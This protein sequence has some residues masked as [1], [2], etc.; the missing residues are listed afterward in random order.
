[1][2][3]L[4]H[5]VKQRASTC[6]LFLILFSI[7]AP[8]ISA[9]DIQKLDISQAHGEAAKYRGKK[10]VHLVAEPLAGNGTPLAVVKGIEFKDGTIEVDVSGDLAKGASDTAR[11]FIG[12][13]FRVQDRSE[14]FELFYLRPTNGR[15]DDQLR[16]NHSTQYESYP[17]WPW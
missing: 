11:G 6:S 17:E 10:A 12:I 16:R 13:A 7:S 4:T 9:Q 8:L 2:N 5:T 1:M 15:A 3:D 14:K